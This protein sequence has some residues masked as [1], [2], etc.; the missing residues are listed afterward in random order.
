MI[1]FYKLYN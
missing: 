1:V